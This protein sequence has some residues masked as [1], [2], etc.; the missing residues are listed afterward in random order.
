MADFAERLDMLAEMVGS[1][2]LIGQVVVDQAYAAI[3]HNS[4]DFNHPRGGQALYLQEPLMTNHSRYL[5]DYART[6]L[7]DGGVPAVIS[8]MEDLAEDG[9]VAT[10]A[11]VLYND[12]RD[13]GHPSVTSD[14]TEVY[15]REPRQPRL[16]EDELKAKY[17]LHHPDPSKLSAR[18]RRFLYASG[19]IPRG[20]E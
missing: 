8:A 19:V 14:G 20:T 3:Q 17:R 9:G 11:P 4:L 7:E 15:D 6:V 16:S 5:D 1:G 13:S 18:E 10:H 12:L 2:D